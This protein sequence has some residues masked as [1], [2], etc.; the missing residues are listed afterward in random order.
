ME[1]VSEQ[2]SAT[3]ST[4]TATEKETAAVEEMKEEKKEVITMGEILGEKATEEDETE[5][6]SSVEYDLGLLAAFDTG[7]LDT[8]RLQDENGDAAAEYARQATLGAVRGLVARLWE[9]PAKETAEARLAHLPRAKTTLPREKPPPEPKPETRWEAFAR[10]KGIQKR[11]RSRMVWD[12]VAKDWLPRYGLGS[13]KKRALGDDVIVEEPD[14][15]PPE[16]KKRWLG[17]KKR[18]EKKKPAD[19]FEERD[20][21]RVK[22]REKQQKNQLR[23]QKKAKRASTAHLGILD[24][25][26]RGPSLQHR[27]GKVDIGEKKKRIT[28][29]LKAAMSSTASMGKFDKEVHVDGTSMPKLK[30]KKRMPAEV[31]SRGGDERQRNSRVVERLLKAKKK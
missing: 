11:K 2:T 27:T 23:N 6:G 13:S 14:N 5:G 30:R 19:P 9:L 12:E 31:A 4:A 21:L 18:P 15:P 10:R 17:K 1:D 8:A 16:P 3:A 28:A 25:D 22:A 24:A 20:Q 29:T 7:Q 26:A